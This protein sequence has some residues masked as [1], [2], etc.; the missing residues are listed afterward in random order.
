MRSGSRPIPKNAAPGHR[1]ASGVSARPYRPH[2][3]AH[4]QLSRKIAHQ[5]V[6][7]PRRQKSFER[8]HGINSHASQCRSTTLPSSCPYIIKTRSLEL[9][10]LSPSSTKCP[11][12]LEFAIST[13]GGIFISVLKFQRGLPDWTEQSLNSSS[14]VFKEEIIA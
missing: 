13:R 3:A 5:N 7:Q 11:Q 2:T 8:S 14:K 12:W 1:A 4:D 9:V 10:E 6:S